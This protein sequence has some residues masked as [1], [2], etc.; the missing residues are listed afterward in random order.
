MNATRARKDAEGE[1]VPQAPQST[2]ASLGMPGH[3]FTLQAVIGLEKS[4]AELGVHIHG[5]K[6]SLD[7]LKGKV[8][9][10]V[11]WKNKIIGGVAVLIFVG[12]VLG[13]LVGKASDYVTFK[14]PVGPQAT[15]TPSTALPPA[16]QPP[17]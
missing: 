14:Q 9:D 4:V 11:G 13:F 12:G 1:S 6:A 8:D 15:P 2:P 5:I 10:L 7:S 17:K 16:I 3:D